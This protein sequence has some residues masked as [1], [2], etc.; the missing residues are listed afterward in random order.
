MSLEGRSSAHRKRTMHS[1]VQAAVH[2][3]RACNTCILTFLDER[4]AAVRRNWHARVTR[5]R[6]CYTQHPRM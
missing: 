5:H 3:S 2:F 4:S 6:K 1:Q